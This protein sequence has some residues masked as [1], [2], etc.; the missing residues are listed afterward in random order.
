M[1]LAIYSDYSYRADADGSVWAEMSVVVFLAALAPHFDRLVLTG[2]LDPEPGRF[3]YPVPPAV[4][5]APLPFYGSLVEPWA[6]VSALA[7]SLRRFWRVLGGVDAV[8]LLGPH[9]FAVLFALVALARRRTV[10]LGVRQDLPAYV[11]NRRPG[12][13]LVQAA[14]EALERAWRL[15]GRRCPVVVVGPDLARRYSGS[16]AVLPIGISLVSERELAPPAA[17]AGRDYG[18][19]ELTA[20]SVGRLDAEKNPLLLADVIA[21]ADPRWR[22][23]VVGD[24]A[25]AGRLAERVREL[26]VEDRVD[27]RGYVAV[28]GD[29]GELY[30]TSHALLHVSWTEG[31]PQVLFE[32]FAAGTPVVGT[33]VG[34]VPAVA[35]SAALLAPAGDPAPLV[36]H[37]LALSRNPG[38]RTTLVRS[39][40]DIIAANTLEVEADRVAGF[41]GVARAPA[42]VVAIGVRD[43]ARATSGAPLR[44]RRSGRKRDSAA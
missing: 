13:R 33:A 21:A 15:L 32:A 43:R 31:V 18:A 8:W 44:E 36:E 12:R 42:P 16:R 29:L 3:A 11:R 34:G 22:L 37:L 1:R 23:V 40:F 9:P 30:R 6:L 39:G 5:F 38:L 25:L 10:V 24:G 4:D 17:L 19:R 2:R 27:L 41:L 20:L 35:G 7:G 14:A 28:G 26:G